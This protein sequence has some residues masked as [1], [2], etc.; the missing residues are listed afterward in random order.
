MR[1]LFT[2]NL[3]YA[4]PNDGVVTVAGIE[5][6]GRLGSNDDVLLDVVSGS[7]DVGGVASGDNAEERVEIN[8]MSSALTINDLEGFVELGAMTGD[9]N[10]EGAVP[11]ASVGGDITIGS[12]YAGTITIDWSGINRSFRGDIVING[13]MTGDI[14]LDNRLSGS[15][16]VDGDFTGT[17]TTDNR[18]AS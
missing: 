15:I 6:S 1:D 10:L 14:S 7:I 17:L 4:D 5:L 18:V 9:I 11:N 16:T 8:S 12:D 2:A 13:D 3:R